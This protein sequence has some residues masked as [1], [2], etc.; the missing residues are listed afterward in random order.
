[1]QYDPSIINDRPKPLYIEAQITNFTKTGSAFAR[2][3][4]GLR[5]VFI[6]VAV[7]ERTGLARGDIVIATTV[8]NKLYESWSPDLGVLQ[9]AQL[10]AVHVTKADAAAI[11]AMQKAAV[12]E[13]VAA[14]P[15]PST[16]DMIL[17]VLKDGPYRAPAIAKKIG[18]Q[19]YTV[20]DELR[21]MH[22]NGI[23]ARANLFSKASQKQASCVIWALK[24]NELLPELD[25]ED[26]DDMP[27]V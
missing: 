24:V 13:Q 22:E 6:P 12:A 20:F 15:K 25:E 17:E 27:D 5:D 19:T 11:E 3:V 10:F 14:P 23:V 18:V 2:E 9:P 21:S 8:P 26:V 1:M 16:R 7:A 4:N